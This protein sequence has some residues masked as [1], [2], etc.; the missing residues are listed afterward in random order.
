MDPGFVPLFAA[1]GP[2]S[3]ESIYGDGLHYVLYNP[4]NQKIGRH[5]L[6]LGLISPAFGARMFQ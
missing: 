3:S 4:L 1:T 2:R 6:M 5:R